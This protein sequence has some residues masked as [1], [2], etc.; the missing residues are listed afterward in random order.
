MTSNKKYFDLL[1]RLKI[2]Y[3]AF[4]GHQNFPPYNEKMREKN[5]ENIK[6]LF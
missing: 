4:D 1:K 5:L 2:T 6:H 3:T